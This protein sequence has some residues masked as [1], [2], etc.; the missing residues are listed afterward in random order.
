MKKIILFVLALGLLLLTSHGAA[1][2]D[3]L[4]PFSGETLNVTGT[5]SQTSPCC[6]TA[7]FT[8]SVTLGSLIPATTDWTVS[9]A[10]F[11]PQNCGASDCSTLMWT[12]SVEFD[13][14]NDTFFGTVSAPF[15]GTH[16]DSREFIETL[17]DGNTSTDPFQNNDLTQ[18]AL[19]DFTNDRSGTFAYTVSA[20]PEPSSALLLACGLLLLGLAGRRA[21]RFAR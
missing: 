19:G 3:S 5:L 14:S 12:S 18:E 16:G 7:S 9:A 10:D 4:T 13:A 2:A 17:I 8:G 6:A 15:T 21:L 11:V 1:Y 20:A